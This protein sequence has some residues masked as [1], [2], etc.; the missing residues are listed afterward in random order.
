MQTVRALLNRGANVLILSNVRNFTYYHIIFFATYA[1]MTSFDIFQ[2]GVSP[3]D[4]AKALD[5]TEL[6]NILEA[7]SVIESGFVCR[8]CTFREVVS[9]SCPQSYY[10]QIQ[11]SRNSRTGYTVSGLENMST[12]LWLQATTSHLFRNTA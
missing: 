6:I 3:V 7:K 11:L 5:H 2:R 10:W 1:I 9:F 4:V 8:N 12:R